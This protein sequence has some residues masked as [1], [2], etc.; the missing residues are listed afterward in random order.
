MRTQNIS[1]T[2]KRSSDSSVHW[3]G[4]LLKFFLLQVSLAVALFAV[5][6][7]GFAFDTYG[8]MLQTTGYYQA[9]LTQSMI[10][11]NRVNGLG[12]GGAASTYCMPPYELQRGADG[13]IPPELQGDPR[14]QEYL[15]CMQHHP[16]YNPNATAVPAPQ[17][18]PSAVAQHQPINIS[19]F[20]PVQPGHPVADQAMATMTVN[21]QQRQIIQNSV[22]QVFS[23]VAKNFRGNNLAVAMAF[24]YATAND[25]LTGVLSSPQQIGQAILNINDAIAQ[26]PNFPQ[27]PAAEKQNTADSLI[28]QSAMILLLRNMGQQDPQA[29]QQSIDLSHIVMKRL[30]GT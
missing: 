1:K 8:A 27:V 6:M 20:A 15:R 26:D 23:Q 10:N 18:V 5:P 14:Y 21:P 2:Q 25:T 7:D 24:A 3:E 9:N 17:N 19:D 11:Y 28:F 4:R 29:K 12:S 16:G 30:T 22:D 13:H